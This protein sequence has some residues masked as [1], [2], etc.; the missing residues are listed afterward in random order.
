MADWSSI[1]QRPLRSCRR[2]AEST[3]RSAGQRWSQA[4]AALS[5]LCCR[6]EHTI[7]ATKQGRT[8]FLEGRRSFLGPLRGARGVGGATHVGPS[9]AEVSA[10]IGCCALA[11]L[12]AG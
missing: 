11:Y 6:A 8:L 10:P 12:P 4:D 1:C 3:A 7:W 9:L 2:S 5:R